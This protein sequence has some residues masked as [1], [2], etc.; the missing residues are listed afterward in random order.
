MEGFSTEDS[1][2]D[3]DTE[4]K[5][6]TEDAAEGV[7]GGMVDAVGDACLLRLRLARRRLQRVA[8]EEEDGVEV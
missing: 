5:A 7:P 8:E 4:S 1:D 3:G 2:E 6:G